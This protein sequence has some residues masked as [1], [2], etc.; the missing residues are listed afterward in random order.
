VGVKFTGNLGVVSTLGVVVVAIICFSLK[1]AQRPIAA[2]IIHGVLLILL[3]FLR[4]DETMASPVAHFPLACVFRPLNR[5][6][7]IYSLI[8]QLSKI[9]DFVVFGRLIMPVRFHLH[10]C[11]DRGCGLSVAESAKI[12]GGG[13]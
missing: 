1:L 4:L 7:P 11:R 12:Q 13:S 9:L 6:Y 8:Q 10:P 3:G 2:L 5:N